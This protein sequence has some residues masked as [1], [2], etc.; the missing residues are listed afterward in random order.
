MKIINPKKLEIEANSNQ[1]GVIETLT[2]QI[3]RDENNRENLQ[4]N[5]LELSKQIKES[6]GLESNCKPIDT[7]SN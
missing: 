3:K 1:S 5:N 2:N 4:N 6:D 7:R